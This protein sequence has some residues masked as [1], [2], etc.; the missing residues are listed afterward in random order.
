[1]EVAIEKGTQSCLGLVFGAGRMHISTGRT[2]VAVGRSLVA[3]GKD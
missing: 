2:Q 3:A 1:M